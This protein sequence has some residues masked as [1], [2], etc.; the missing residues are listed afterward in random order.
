MTY[1]IF[2]IYQVYALPNRYAT[3]K[4]HIYFY[5]NYSTRLLVRRATVLVFEQNPHTN[6]GL[7][8]LWAARATLALHIFRN[9]ALRILT[10]TTTTVI[11]FTDGGNNL[12]IQLLPE[13]VCLGC[14]VCVV[15]WV[16]VGASHRPWKCSRTADDERIKI[17]IYL[18]RKC[19]QYVCVCV[20]GIL[21]IVVSIDMWEES[22]GETDWL[23][24]GATWNNKITPQSNVWALQFAGWGH[25][26]N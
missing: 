23:C 11:H 24:V 18:Q 25:K 21:C 22:C 6:T 13:P 17:Y 7:G 9:I 19:I 15:Y 4:I 20:C 1:T 2:M 3:L 10:T 12:H 14:V 26:Y 16:N 8:A 5:C